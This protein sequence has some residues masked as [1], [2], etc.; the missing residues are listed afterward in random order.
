MERRRM[1][2]SKS[3]INKCPTG[4]KT[5]DEQ[6][7]LLQTHLT[8]LLVILKRSQV[9]VT[10]VQDMVFKVKSY[11]YAH[12]TYEE[13]LMLKVSK[14]AATDNQ[15]AHAEFLRH[16]KSL[17]E[18]IELKPGKSY[19]HAVTLTVLLNTWISNHICTV[20]CKLRTLVERMTA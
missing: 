3:I 15:L 10:V 11:A 7:L 17:E 9:D 19:D 8:K 13:E 16:L 1:A 6:H 2:T 20:D 5:I 18:H 4:I 12:F 14:S